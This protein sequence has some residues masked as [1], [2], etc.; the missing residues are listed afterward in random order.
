VQLDADVIFGLHGFCDDDW[1]VV[2]YWGADDYSN[3]VIV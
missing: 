1:M 2:V 3:D